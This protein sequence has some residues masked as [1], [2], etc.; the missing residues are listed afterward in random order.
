MFGFGKK[1]DEEVDLSRRNFLKGASVIVPAGIVVAAGSSLGSEGKSEKVKSDYLKK[2]WVEDGITYMEYDLPQHI[3]PFFK[4]YSYVGSD[5][6]E[7]IF[8]NGVC[9]PSDTKLNDYQLKR[10]VDI[11]KGLWLKCE[12]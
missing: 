6:S 5:V 2:T 4:K 12:K 3:Q 7:R 10:V 8:S 9:L 1:D 11:L